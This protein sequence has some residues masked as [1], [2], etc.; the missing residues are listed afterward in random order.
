MHEN[1]FNSPS[2]PDVS[3]PLFDILLSCYN[4]TLANNILSSHYIREH[5][6]ANND[7]YT[8]LYVCVFAVA[9]NSTYCEPLKMSPME[10]V[11]IASHFTLKLMR[12]RYKLRYSS[13]SVS[14]LPPCKYLPTHS[15]N[16]HIWAK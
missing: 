5:T 2:S 4:D 3:F 8:I 10:C 12:V 15:Q 11:D 9:M 1:N 13:V 14:L 6:I 16:L 7:S